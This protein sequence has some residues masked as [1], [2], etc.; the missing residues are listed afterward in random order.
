MPD[1]FDDDENKVK[2]FR[3]QELVV[4]TEYEKGIAKKLADVAKV[5]LFEPGFALYNRNDDADSVRFVLSGSLKLLDDDYK[6]IAVVEA[7]KSIGESPLADPRRKYTV[8]AIA[9]EPSHIARVSYGAFLEIAKGNAEIWNRL[10]VKVTQ[11]LN[12]RLYEDA[13]RERLVILVHGILT[14]ADWQSKVGTVLKNDDNLE[15]HVKPPRCRSFRSAAYLS[16]THVQFPIAALPSPVVEADSNRP[17]ISCP[18]D[19]TSSIYSGKADKHPSRRELKTQFA[20]IGQWIS[21]S[22]SCC[23][24]RSPRQRRIMRTSPSA[25]RRARASC[26]APISPAMKPTLKG[27]VPTDSC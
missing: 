21:A 1:Y 25:R 18:M 15:L 22:V 23:R 19:R 26:C 5:E 14:F 2:G 17:R 8:T 12:M 6:L 24:K 20:V 16:C 11:R 7:G 13:T 9:R 27:Q 4:G 3:Q 10:F